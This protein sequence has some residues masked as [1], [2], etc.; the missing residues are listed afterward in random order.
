MRTFD[1]VPALVVE[2]FDRTANGSRVHVEDFAQVLGVTG[3]QKYQ[4]YGGRVTL[5]RVAEVLRQNDPSSLAALA[6]MVVAAVAI[7]LTNP[8]MESWRWPS[9]GSIDT[10]P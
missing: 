8:P 10:R 3:N 9:A 7:W 1:D 4:R 6:R 5:A 2:R